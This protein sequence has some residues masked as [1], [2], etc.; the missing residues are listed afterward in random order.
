MSM[1]VTCSMP[2]L[3]LHLQWCQH[4]CLLTLMPT[5]TLGRPGH[6]INPSKVLPVLHALQG[7][8]ES[9]KLWESHINSILFS[10]ELNFKCTKHDRTIYSTTFRGVKVLLLCQ[11]N[12]FALASP[13]EDIAKAIYDI[14]GK[15]LTLPGEDKPPFAYMGLVDDYNGIQVKQSSHFVSISVRIWISCLKPMDGITPHLMKPLLSTRPFRSLLRLLPPYT[16]N[17][18]LL[19]TLKSILTLQ[20]NKASHIAPFLVSL[21]TPM[22]CVALISAIT[23]LLSASSPL[24]LLQSIIPCLKILQDIFVGP[25]RGV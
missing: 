23:S 2:L 1:V 22:L 5:G 16:R 21:Y 4:M 17:R 7:H 15:P 18:A 8:P 9:G 25:A 24:R 20:T 11:V 19:K 13:D 6:K 12:D 10:P 3:I 14:I